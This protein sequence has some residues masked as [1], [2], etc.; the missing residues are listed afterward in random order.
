MVLRGTNF[1]CSLIVL[2][3]ISTTFTIFNTTKS[4]PPRNN[5]P[6][7]AQGTS[8]WP[9]ITLLCVACVSLFMSVLVFHGYWKGGHRRA[10]KVAI[11]YSIFAV[12]FFTFSIV[13]WAIAAAVLHQSKANGNGQDMWGWSCKDNT[14]RTLFQEEVHYNLICRLQVNNA[15]LLVSFF[16]FFYA[17]WT[18]TLTDPPQNWSLVCAIIE[19]V[20][21]T[22]TIAIYGIVFY[23]YYSLRRLRKSMATR[24]RARS[25]LYLAQLR[26]QSA[27]NTPGF[28]PMSAREGGYNPMFSPR[29]DPNQK[30]IAVDEYSAAELGDSKSVRYLEAPVQAVPKKPFTLQAPPTRTTPKMPQRG[31]EPQGLAPGPAPLM[32]QVPTVTTAQARPPPMSPSSAAVQSEPVHQPAAPGEQQYGAVPIP[33]AYA[34]PLTSPMHAPAQAGY[35][36]PVR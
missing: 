9:Q 29:W 3:M 21:E 22:I 18:I 8:T 13:M 26:S 2:S 31:F 12:A 20:V 7:W 5:L 32:L 33:G 35:F 15:T 6:P 11:Y 4:L 27:P 19:I 14:R 34:S 17:P 30:E 28:A 1:S 36:A 10:E 25:D 16:F 24:D 23:R